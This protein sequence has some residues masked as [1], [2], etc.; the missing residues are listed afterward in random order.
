MGIV[1]GGGGVCQPW[2]WG[3]LGHMPQAAQLHCT[4]EW[5]SS[6]IVTA[7]GRPVS[8]W[9]AHCMCPLSVDW[10]VLVPSGWGFALPSPPVGY[11]WVG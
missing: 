3:V 8:G 10:G 9:C 2:G 5:A 6:G 7:A 1:T 11:V 4:I